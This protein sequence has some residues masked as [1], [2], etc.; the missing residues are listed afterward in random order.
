MNKII[1]TTDRLFMAVCGPSCC[2]KTELIFKMLLQNTFSPMFESIF[3]FYQHEQPK[4]QFIERKFLHGLAW[5]S[6]DYPYCYLQQ[7]FQS[8]KLRFP[9]AE[10]Y[11]K[12]TEKAD[13][14]KKLLQ[15]DV[16]NLET[17]LCPKF[18]NL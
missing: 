7:I 15:R 2:G 13:T 11:A 4:F 10:F 1:S 18:E 9:F 5:E 8:I 6:G 17:L 3:Y 12:G 14:L 16:I